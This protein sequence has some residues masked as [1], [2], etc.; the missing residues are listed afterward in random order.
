MEFNVKL[1]GEIENE[2]EV[3]I[4]VERAREA[5]GWDSV[6]TWR[7]A[8]LQVTARWPGSQVQE[9]GHSPATAPTIT[10]TTTTTTTSRGAGGITA[11]SPAPCPQAGAASSHVASC[12]LIT[13]NVNSTCLTCHFIASTCV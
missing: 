1:S 11:P 2:F 3:W 8:L 6:T 10:S 9:G 7:L 5:D 4:N 12:L 13:G